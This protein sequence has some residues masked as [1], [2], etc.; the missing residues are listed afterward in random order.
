VKTDV[1]GVN[2]VDETET[3]FFNDV[4]LA[5]AGAMKIAGGLFLDTA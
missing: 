1:P 2:E 4:A 5:A 3:A